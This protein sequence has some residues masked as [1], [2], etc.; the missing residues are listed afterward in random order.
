MGDALQAETLPLFGPSLGLRA[1]PSRLNCEIQYLVFAL[2]REL[3]PSETPG[4]S[5]AFRGIKKP[6]TRDMRPRSCA[7]HSVNPNF[8]FPF[9]FA[10]GDDKP[11]PKV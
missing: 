9:P 10:L 7:L 8:P 1:R 5:W 2:K 6:R 3:Q 4:S 11:V